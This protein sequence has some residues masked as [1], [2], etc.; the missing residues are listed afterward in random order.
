MR[1]VGAFTTTH[2]QVELAAV[3]GIRQSSISDAKRRRSCPADWLVSLLGLGANPAW[4]LS[5]QGPRYMVPSEDG[6]A[7]LQREVLDALRPQ[8]EPVE[9]SAR[10]KN[11]RRD[12]ERLLPGQRV[13][14]LVLP[15]QLTDEGGLCSLC[16]FASGKHAPGCLLGHELMAPRLD[17]W[18]DALPLGG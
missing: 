16:G 11:L 2:T 6:H 9:V 3:L 12:V 18:E 15:R 5:G 4:I 8:P 10:L 7:P 17:G 1:R 13:E 14:V